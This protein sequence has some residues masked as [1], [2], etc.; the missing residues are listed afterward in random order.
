MHPDAHAACARVSL[1]R[2]RRR[3]RGLTL[4]ELLVTVAVAAVVL[5]AS[6]PW[7]TSVSSRARTLDAQAQA[8]TAAAYAARVLSDD[9]GLA[10][11]LLPLPAGAVAGHALNVRHDHP[12]EPAEPIL[13]S[14]DP[15]RRVLWRKAP[16]TYLADHVEDCS[17]TLF[18]DDGQPLTPAQTSSP[19]LLAGVVRVH[20]SITVAVR[21]ETATVATDL[22]VGPL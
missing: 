20:V 15:A 3:E 10:T 22:P 18:T 2:R 12:G 7:V 11:G 21:T 1:R 6:L 9:L 17:F 4:M 14:W 19:D 8:A 13:I 16:G 5:G